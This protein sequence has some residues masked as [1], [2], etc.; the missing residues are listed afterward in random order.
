MDIVYHRNRSRFRIYWCRLSK[1]RS[2][3]CHCCCTKPGLPKVGRESKEPLASEYT[4]FARLSSLF[5]YL[6]MALC[7]RI[8][9]CYVSSQNNRIAY[10]TVRDNQDNYHSSFLWVRLQVVWLFKSGLLPLTKQAGGSWR[11]AVVY[12]VFKRKSNHHRW[13]RRY[14]LPASPWSWCSSNYFWISALKRLSVRKE[15]L[16]TKSK[17]LC[18]N[19]F[20]IEASVRDAD[21]VVGGAYPWCQ[22]T[23]ISNRWDGQTNASGSVIVDVAVDQGGV[24]ETADRV[25]TMN[26]SMKNTVFSRYAVT[27]SLVRF[28]RT[29]T[30]A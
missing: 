1:A 14:M 20:N 28:A 3:D 10:E 9:R 11:S 18:K 24:I 13:C 2:W 5:T 27:I 7:S 17:L 12:Q 6:H 21:V 4:L 8:S 30:I 23:E 22:S 26:P 25:T 19:S 15:S 16:E 29:S